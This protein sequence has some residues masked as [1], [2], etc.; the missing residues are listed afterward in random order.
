V[1]DAIEGA[2]DLGV[3]YLTLFSFSTEKWSRPKDENQWSQWIV[4]KNH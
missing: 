2:E 1:K 3:E 4:G